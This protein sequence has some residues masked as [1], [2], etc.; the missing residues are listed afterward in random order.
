VKNEDCVELRKD[1]VILCN[2][3]LCNIPNIRTHMKKDNKLHEVNSDI[4]S[5]IQIIEDEMGD[6]REF[7][8]LISQNID[9]KRAIE[10]ERM[11]KFYM[12]RPSMLSMKAE[13]R[14]VNRFNKNFI[15]FS[16]NQQLVLLQSY[17]EAR[18]M[19]MLG[20][21]NRHMKHLC[22]IGK[23]MGSPLKVIK[24]LLKKELKFNIASDTKVW[25]EINV[26]QSIRNWIVHHYSYVP[27]EK[28]NES[29]SKSENIAFKTI[30]NSKHFELKYRG[31]YLKDSEY[32]VVYS[33]RVEIYLISILKKIETALYELS[34]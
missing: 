34:E 17:I 15:L 7:L 5:F 19:N 26:N 14:F 33:K 18:L 25:Q 12:K 23:L 21:V 32:L 31:F 30:T 13:S 20:L 1:C 27:R 22:N 6:Y 11:D 29:M 28:E 2:S 9:K 3:V 4:D 10:N 24:D 16:Y 8:N